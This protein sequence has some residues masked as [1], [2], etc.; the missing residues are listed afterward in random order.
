MNN[1]AYKRLTAEEIC[2]K[3]L[4]C[5]ENREKLLIIAHRNPDG[6]AVGSAFALRSIY[7]ALGGEAKCAFADPIPDYLGFLAV[8]QEN[9]EYCENEEYDC[10]I[11]VDTASIQQMGGL[12]HLADKVS[13]AIDHHAMGEQY[14]DALIDGD[15]SAAGEIIYEIY[16]LLIEKGKLLED[17][18]V[19]RLIYAA[20]TADTGSFRYS[21][22]TARTHKAV[23]AI[24]EAIN[25]DKDG[26][27]TAEIARLIHDSKSMANLKATKLCIDK[28]KTAEGVKITYAVIE[29]SDIE[30]AGISDEDMGACIDVPRSVA[31]SLLSFVLKEGKEREEGK[32]SFRISARSSCDI[33]VAEI[34][35][36]FGGGGHAKAAGG[37]VTAESCEEAEKAVLSEFLAALNEVR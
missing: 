21:N 12:S 13:F 11:T 31:G 26:M 28:M 29:R 27:S 4:L 2:E 17:A 14:C 19:Y 24:I 30:N 36:K 16:S 37:A 5:A 20:I 32:R 18:D 35:R 15:A 6:D 34:C 23:A 8:E 3:L 1:K 33:S 9:V 10:M 7:K 25:S 22:T